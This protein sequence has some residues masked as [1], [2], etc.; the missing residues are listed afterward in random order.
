MIKSRRMKWE[1][2]AARMGER[3]GVYSILVGNLR[4]IDHME[5]TGLDGR[6]IFRK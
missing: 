4:E 6:K 5:D 1:G 2:R 3:R